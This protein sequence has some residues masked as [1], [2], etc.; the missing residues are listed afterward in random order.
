MGGVIHRSLLV[1]AVVLALASGGA[2]QPPALPQDVPPGPYVTGPEAVRRVT[3]YLDGDVEGRCFEAS[4]AVY[5][6]VGGARSGWTMWHIDGL[7]LIGRNGV[8]TPSHWFLR[9]PAGRIVDL[10]DAQFDAPPPYDRAVQATPGTFNRLP[11]RWDGGWVT[12]PAASGSIRR[13][14]G[15]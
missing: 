13:E 9:D 3:A 12:T 7:D 1:V 14:A 8:P 2:A 15:P 10:T 5:T 11:R 4:L 6:L